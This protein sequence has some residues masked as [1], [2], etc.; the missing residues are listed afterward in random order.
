MRTSQSQICRDCGSEKAREFHNFPTGPNSNI[1]WINLCDDCRIKRIRRISCHDS[2]TP[3]QNEIQE[4]IK[5]RDFLIENEQVV[6]VAYKRIVE[7]IAEEKWSEISDLKLRI[8]KRVIDTLIRKVKIF[9][10]QMKV[11]PDEVL[12]RDFFKQRREKIKRLEGLQKKLENT[13]GLRNWIQRVEKKVNENNDFVEELYHIWK[14][15][16][17]EEIEIRR[18]ETSILSG[19]TVFISGRLVGLT[20]ERDMVY[21][22]LKEKGSHV[23]RF[24]DRA[25]A[26]T[27]REACLKWA[28]ECDI[29]IGIYGESYGDVVED[30]KSATEMEFV[31]STDKGIHR[32]IFIKS[33]TKEHRQKEFIN[34]MRSWDD[35]SSLVYTSFT[36]LE[37]L[38]LELEKSINELV[39]R[40]IIS[41]KKGEFTK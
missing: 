26:Q 30:G 8:E 13:D 37:D 31:A 12:D 10:E 25:S 2:V 41:T 40:G 27:P 35:P 15:E 38:R 7:W 39:L 17:K 33:G 22:Y 3:I 16:K 11:V 28:T 18:E 29:Y 24:E 1:N 4:I 32:L 21:R 5:M 6:V 34:R 19:L 23:L 9:I 36:D 14:K 20:D